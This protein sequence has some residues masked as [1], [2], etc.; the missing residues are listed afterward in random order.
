MINRVTNTTS[1]VVRYNKRMRIQRDVS[2]AKHS[3]MRLGGNADY[4]VNI[5]EK[6]DIPNALDW[7]AE[8]KLPTV[9][10]GG[11][12]NIIWKDSGF[13]G[14]VMVNKIPGFEISELDSDTVY[15]KVGAGENWDKT[16][17]RTVKKGLQGIEGLSLI[18]GTAGGAPVQNIGAYGQDVSQTLVSVEVYDTKTQ[19]F[20]SLVNEECHFGYRTSRFKY[21]DKGRFYICSLTFALARKSPEPPFYDSLQRYIDQIGIT[22]YTPASI[23][24]IVIAIRSSRLP[25]P[26]KVANNGSFFANPIISE[27]RFKVLKDK[28]PS[29]PGWPVVGS[30][31]RK[32]VKVPAGWLI[33]QAGFKGFHDR[34]TG[35]ATWHAQALVLVNEK[36]ESTA[37]LLI[38]RNRIIDEIKD[39]FGITLEQ[40][41][42][43]LP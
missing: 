37:D 43:I 21:K 15:V 36:A 18:P 8:K 10:I 9:M 38:F 29:I 13:K 33:E 31:N 12:S 25:D 40:E 32:R 24:E 11:G 35:M 41:P 28:Y 42:E 26:A 23:R 2:L 4:L 16:V 27:S 20:V 7:A 22:E 3:T 5:K 34:K 6:S 14:L 19:Q 17:E 1:P 39:K 30:T